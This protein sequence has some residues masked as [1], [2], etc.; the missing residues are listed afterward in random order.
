KEVFPQYTQQPQHSEKSPQPLYP[1]KHPLQAKPIASTNFRNVPQKSQW[2]SKVFHVDVGVNFSHRSMS[3]K[4]GR[5][6]KEAV[7]NNCRRYI[8]I[9]TSP[10]DS[11]RV[12]S[13]V[14]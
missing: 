14:K 8:V 3:T 4:I 11:K 6:I 13:I 12:L 2:S 9:S 7:T 1:E 5:L 10:I